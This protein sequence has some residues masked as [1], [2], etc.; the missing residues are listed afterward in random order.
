MLPIDPTIPPAPAEDYAAMRAEGYAEVERLGHERWTDYN[1]HDPGITLLENLLYAL[2]ETGYRGQFDI[3]DLL[4]GP[5]GGIDH[6]QPFFTAR[7]IL[8]NA[9]I[10]NDDYRRLLIDSLG[11]SNAWAVCKSCA[12]G[13]LAYAECADGEL[14]A[15]PRWRTREELRDT[16][17]THEHPVVVRGF[18]DILLQFAPDPELGNLNSHR[19]DG[20]L[21]P[22]GR[23][24]D[25]E[26][27][28]PDWRHLSERAFL[29]VVDGA[30][31]LDSGEVTR[32][33]RDRTLAEPVDA[34]DFRRGLRDIF[35]LD[36]RLRFRTGDGTVLVLELT[37]VT[38]RLWPRAAESPATTDG[39]AIVTEL[40]GSDLFRRYLR[41]LQQRAS[42]LAASSELLHDN[43]KVGEDF[44]RFDRIRAEDIAVC[45]DLH[46][47]PGADVE[48]TLAQFYRTIER[49]FNPAV[50]FR[51]LTELEELGQPTEE[52]FTGPPLNHGFILQEDL[53]GSQLRS[54]IYVSDLVNELMDIPG[55]S[56]IE[57]LRFTNY[58]D[59]GR[60]V[61]P[62]N[63]WC[64]PVRA[65]HYPNLYVAASQVAAYKDGLPLLPR[66][67]ELR[68]VL[69]QLR[70][71][72]RALALAVDQLDYPVPVGTHRPPPA[73]VP[74][75]RTL[76]ATYG[77]SEEGVAEGATEQ[78]KGRARQLAGYLYPLEM[79]TAATAAQ[80]DQ[81]GDLFSTDE[82]IATTYPSPDLVAPDGPLAQLVDPLT[83]GTTADALAEILEDTDRFTDRRNRFLD[84]LLARFGESLTD[85]TLL[86]HDQETRR[87]FGGEKLIR[88]KVRFLR[89]YP[90]ISGRRGTGINYRRAAGV[91]TYTNRSGLGERIRRLLGMEDVR[92]YFQLDTERTPEGWRTGFTFGE[93]DVLM[94]ISPAL[95][96]PFPDAT[97]SENQA[98]EDI[99]EIVELATDTANYVTP[100]DDTELRNADGDT[101]AILSDTALPTDIA[102]LISEALLSERLYVVEHIL[103][104]PKFP[105]DA[106][107]SV[108]LNDDCEHHGLED[109]YSFRITYVLPADV[110]PFSEDV[111]LR[112]LAERTIRRET[113]VYLLPKIC[114][115]SDDP[116]E[117]EYTPEELEELLE[118]CVCPPPD[119][120]ARQL[121][122]F[123]ATYCA[124]LELNKDFDWTALTDEL[125]AA[126]CDLL[127]LEE[128]EA[129]RLLLGYYGE[130]FRQILGA[131]AGAM[132]TV[133]DGDLRANW[134][135]RVWSGFLD[136][137]ETI[138]TNDFGLYTQW[139]LT[140]DPERNALRELLESFYDDWLVVSFRLHRL[141]LVFGQLRSAY[142]TAT[143]HD[144]DDGD[145]DRPVRLDQTTLGTL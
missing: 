1:A 81:F 2:A 98:W 34:D 118:S 69:S 111:D 39:A 61:L 7:H 79:I 38:L 45:A 140:G 44:C 133:D 6:R 30:T 65:G 51:T 37:E 106:L 12:C 119:E 125:R 18:T 130:N 57:A 33:S 91:C 114:W 56:A 19:L 4:T 139:G 82:G 87:Q 22:D 16:T 24:F 20:Q 13:P 100:G 123:E 104:R 27:R 135:G 109:P 70:A 50:P 145:D 49:L 71:D 77:L 107:M 43:R 14:S 31:E 143:L 48:A 124:Y 64:I 11:L 54:V 144:C 80:L 126:V 25:A 92:S 105:G 113:P 17:S 101:L 46:L 62:A 116:A 68:S 136:D 132:E 72:D 41:K 75:Q 10:T 89:F 122:R 26:L 29:A 120:L 58:D 128:G 102:D 94:S 8:T 112:R 97:A 9:P 86:I 32:F 110:R 66:R 15:A 21:L 74:V 60:P 85:Y 127:E 23:T 131:D 137:L 134:S 95:R 35:F 129:A 42:V 47:T 40:E 84:H 67:A 36:L 73:Y 108:C 78:R 99:R 142:P 121:S 138:R 5:G 115:I 53:D 88:D 76:P 55:V 63:E 90:K 103:L 117:S 83:A 28:F 52:I 3:A 96:R 59:D 93:E 141:L